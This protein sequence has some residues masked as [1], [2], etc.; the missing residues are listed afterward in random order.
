MGSEMCIR[1]R[2]RVGELKV[3]P[4]IKH[5]ACGQ[6][7]SEHVN[8]LIIGAGAGAVEILA[9]QKP[10]GKMLPIAEFLR[11]YSFPAQIT[12]CS[13]AEKLPLCR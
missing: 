8:S 12:F 5:L 6:R 13:T 2:F 1:D 9:L 7:C 11:G 4:A 10:G 3:H